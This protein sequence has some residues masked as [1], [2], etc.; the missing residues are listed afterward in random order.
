MYDFK[1]WYLLSC[2]ARSKT[3]FKNLIN[4]HHLFCWKGE[5]MRFRCDPFKTFSCII[6]SIQCFNFPVT[7][8]VC[9]LSQAMNHDHVNW[10]ISSI[11][12][13]HLKKLIIMERR[14]PSKIN[15]WGLDENTILIIA[16]TYI[17]RRNTWKLHWSI[18]MKHSS[19]SSAFYYKSSS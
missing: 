16:L 19:L 17:P 11:C 4:V 2:D 3:S 15:R 18:A 9:L 10:T 14:F 13:S 8:T 1:K 12:S 5:W 6:C 7:C